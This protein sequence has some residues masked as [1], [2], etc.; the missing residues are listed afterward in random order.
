[1]WSLRQKDEVWQ[2]WAQVCFPNFTHLCNKSYVSDGTSN[3]IDV[4]L[5]CCGSGALSI[6]FLCPLTVCGESLA[7]GNVTIDN[8]G[9]LWYLG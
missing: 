4:N 6:N 8:I 9:Y 2:D 3:V 1:M 7:L 5:K